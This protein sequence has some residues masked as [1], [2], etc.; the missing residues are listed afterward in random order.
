MCQASSEEVFELLFLS[1]ANAA[2]AK[3]FISV[4]AF[5]QFGPNTRSQF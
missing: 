2:F 4:Q 3:L 5:Y 1:F